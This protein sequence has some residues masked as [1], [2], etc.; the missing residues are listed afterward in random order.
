[1]PMDN[2]LLDHVVDNLWRIRSPGS[3]VDIPPFPLDW[4]HQPFCSNYYAYS[5]SLTQPPYSENV[6][7]IIQ[8]EALVISSRQASILCFFKPFST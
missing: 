5:G 4:L 7:W 8:P 3:S 1:M 2:P 6:T